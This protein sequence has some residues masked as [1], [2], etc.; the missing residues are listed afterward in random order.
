MNLPHLGFLNPLLI[1][2]VTA[3]LAVLLV[4]VGFWWWWPK[5]EI[6]RLRPMIIDSAARANAED[7][8]R[9]TI[10]QLLGGAAVLIGAALAYLQFT[11]QQQTS[12]RQF[13]QQQQTS[14]RQFLQQQQTSQDLFISNQLAKGFEQLGQTGS[15]KMFLRLGGVYA[16][17]GVMNASQF[18]QIYYQT[19]Y[20]EA[21]G[22]DYLIND[23]HNYYNIALEGLSVFVRDGSRTDN[24]DGPPANDIQ[25]ALTVAL[26][27]PFGSGLLDLTN[28]HIPK[29]NLRNVP[30]VVNLSGADLRGADLTDARIE[31]VRLD[32][33]DL[34]GA[35]ITQAQLDQ[36][37]CGTDVKL[38]PG[39]TVKPCSTSPPAK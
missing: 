32:G 15:D 27:H 22:R 13:L 10:G 36:G 29:A 8:I 2:K 20:W 17:E 5:R 35:T 21:P 33:A 18:Y 3:G 23:Y 38:D 11:E 6:G 24:G 26:R 39:R 25:A 31:Y 16:L 7:N 4:A 1:I 37:V 9:K 12:Q 30:L 14:Q 19:Y 28:A 34:R